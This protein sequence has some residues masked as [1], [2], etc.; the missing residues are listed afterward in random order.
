MENMR[1]NDRVIDL[2]YSYRPKP[3]DRRESTARAEYVFHC[4]SILS[5]RSAVPTAKLDKG[6]ANKAPDEEKG[7]WRSKLIIQK[8]TPIWGCSSAGRAP[9]LQA[10][11]HGFDSHHLHQPTVSA[12]KIDKPSANKAP[13]KVDCGTVR[14][15]RYTETYM[16]S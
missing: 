1:D 13:E 3:K 9:A 12:A 4:C 5:D 2:S 10:G 15:T 6:S 8:K 11:G 14:E 16:G 7:G